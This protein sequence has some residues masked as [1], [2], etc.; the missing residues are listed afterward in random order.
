MQLT[1]DGHKAYLEAVETAFHGD[2]D[3]ALLV[4]LYGNNPKED[5]RKYSFLK[6][7]GTVKGVVTGN[8]EKN[9]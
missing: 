2:I 8:P 9:T 1:T 6:F 3:D 7:K 5:Q 4:K